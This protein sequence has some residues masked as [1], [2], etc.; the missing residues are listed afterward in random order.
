MFGFLKVV[1]SFLYGIKLYGSISIV[2]IVSNAQHV[3]LVTWTS[4]KRVIL[5]TTHL[6]SDLDKS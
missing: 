1:F 5:C 6:W 3:F 4:P 2:E